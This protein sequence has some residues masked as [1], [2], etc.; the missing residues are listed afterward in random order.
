MKKI[1]LAFLIWILVSACTSFDLSD[2]NA[3]ITQPNPEIKRV[4]VIDFDFARPERGRT[5]RG[6]ITR[7]MNAGSIMA[8]IFAEHLL[9]SGLYDVVERRKVARLMRD[10]EIDTSDLFAAD[11]IS[12]MQQVLNVDGLVVGV[13]TEYGDWRGRLN[14]GGVVGFSARLVQI[15]SGSLIWAASANRD[16]AMTN[17]T[18][19]AHAASQEA[20]E[21]LVAK[22]GR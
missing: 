12:K 3:S 15:N 13:V 7:P 11:S 1:M 21:D 14:W 19:I 20:L 8:D 17:S 16:M 10:L 18:A 5:D 22:L 6:R 2:H 9:A 4:A